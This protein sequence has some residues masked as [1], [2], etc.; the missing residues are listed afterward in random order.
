MLGYYRA[1]KV[2]PD[3]EWEEFESSLRSSLPMAMR[4]LRALWLA[5]HPRRAAR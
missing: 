3:E 2:C 1:Q 4:V 5:A